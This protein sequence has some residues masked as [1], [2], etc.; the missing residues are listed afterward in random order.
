LK[1][2][3]FVSTKCRKVLIFLYNAPNR[4][5]RYSK[6]L[7]SFVS[8]LLLPVCPSRLLTSSLMSWIFL[9]VCSSTART[10]MEL[11]LVS[12]SNAVLPWAPILHQPRP[13]TSKLQQPRY[14][15]LHLPVLFPVLFL[16]SPLVSSYL[17]P[18]SE[19][20]K[21]AVEAVRCSAPADV[22]FGSF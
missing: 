4:N 9:L 3:T 15:S 13:I 8:L 22:D 20:L 10:T 5:V 21:P 7:T 17:L 2:Y 18:R 11:G 12:Q 19:H 16:F 14:I 1:R 6:I